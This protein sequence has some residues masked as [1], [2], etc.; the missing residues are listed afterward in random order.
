MSSSWLEYPG[1]HLSRGVLRVQAFALAA[2]ESGHDQAIRDWGLLQRTRLE[3]CDS[4]E[5]MSN[6]AVPESPEVER[7][8]G[9][10]LHAEAS[11]LENLTWTY[12]R[13]SRESLPPEVDGTTG[14]T[15]TLQG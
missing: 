6:D 13:A 5:S 8:I 3:P 12:V 1:N 2:T 15:I 10:I 4:G 11:G 7:R 14:C 9:S